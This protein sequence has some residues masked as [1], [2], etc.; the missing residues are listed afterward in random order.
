MIFLFPQVG[1]VSFLEGNDWFPLIKALLN[2]Y[3]WA[4]YVRGG[5]RLTS[6]EAVFSQILGIPTQKQ[7]QLKTL[8]RLS[9]L[10]WFFLKRM[11]NREGLQDDFSIYIYI[12]IHLYTQDVC[13][14]CMDRMICWFLEAHYIQLPNICNENEHWAKKWWLFCPGVCTWRI[15]QFGKCCIAM[16]DVSFVNGLLMAKRMG[17]LATVAIGVALMTIGYLISVGA[18]KFGIGNVDHEDSNWWCKPW[19]QWSAISRRCR[20]RTWR[21]HRN[22]FWKVGTDT[23]TIRYPSARTLSIGC[24]SN[25]VSLSSSEEE[26]Q[27]HDELASTVIEAFDRCVH[28]VDESVLVSGMI[29]Q[30]PPRNW[31]NGANIAD[32]WKMYVLSKMV[33]I[34]ASSFSLPEGTWMSQEGS[35]WLANGL[36]PTYKWGILGLQPTY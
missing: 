7:C 28:T 17:L 18:I 1:Y 27:P 31:R 36:Q 35:K 15:I 24:L 5:V 21:N 19:C 8:G 6:H 26:E 4:S 13:F 3:F 2:P 20:W 29:H 34:P 30:V 9:R 11:K 22:S 23:K 10:V 14:S 32:P 33:D 25:H 12:C 16:V